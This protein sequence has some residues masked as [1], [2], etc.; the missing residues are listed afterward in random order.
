MIIKVCGMRVAENIRQVK[1]L[2]VD[3]IGLVFC[4]ESPR[5]VTQVFASGGFVPDYSSFEAE[6]PKLGGMPI[7]QY[8]D[9]H[10]KRVGVFVDDM[11]QT[12]VTKVAIYHLDYVQ[13]HGEE[14]TVMIENL[15]AT[16]Y[17]DISTNV[18]II[19]TIP[20]ETAADFGKCTPYVGLVDYFLFH[21]KCE[22]KGGSGEKFDWSILGEYNLDVPFLIS[23]GIGPDDVEAVKAISHPQF[24]GIDVNS[25][26]E[27]EPAVK[28]V[29]KLKPFV[30]ALRA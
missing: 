14:S 25:K 24:A 6:Q 10:P 19:K 17:P 8:L 15:K 16:L 26:F 27:T 20:V 1:E 28:D 12:I 22:Q 23:G 13:L 9:N 2:G 4:P 18:K 3:W 11:P 21:N 7:F 29:K 30:E 5:Y